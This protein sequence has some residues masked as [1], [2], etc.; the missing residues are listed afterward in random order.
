MEKP[1]WTVCSV[2]PESDYT[3]HLRFADGSQ[4]VYDARGL[5]DEGP[6][7]PLRDVELFLE[8][9]VEFGTVVWSD[10][11]DIAPEHLYEHSRL[12]A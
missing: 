8:A 11:I 5:L 10:D 6:F 3:L 12:A 4:R 1:C 9:R 2:H 7:L